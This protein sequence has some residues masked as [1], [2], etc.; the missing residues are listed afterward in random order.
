[1]QKLQPVVPLMSIDNLDI[2]P[3]FPYITHRMNVVNFK[4]VQEKIIKFAYD[5]RDKDS[6]GMK[7]SNEGGWHSRNDYHYDQDHFLRK[8]I[9]DNL[10]DYFSKSDAM[11]NEISYQIAGLW[12][13]IN[14]PGSLNKVHMHPR[15]HLS[16][17]F[18]IKV[19]KNSGHIRFE[20]RDAWS[21]F[22]EWDQYNQG[23]K[24]GFGLFSHYSIFA[25]E[26]Q[27]LMFPAFLP[28]AVET[29]ESSED[30][31]SVSFNVK[32]G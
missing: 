24:D 25:N 19:P 11:I 12:V 26:G 18:W 1:M 22:V 32:F 17:A 8:I 2:L 29:N 16:G 10:S 30:R 21:Q 7:L 3:L 20:N 31:I 27:I 23:F 14:P 9:V 4:E 28:H 15:C 5:E 6:N 13:N